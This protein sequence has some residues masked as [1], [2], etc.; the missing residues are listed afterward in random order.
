[1]IFTTSKKLTL[2]LVAIILVLS[3]VGVSATWS[4]G[5]AQIESKQANVGTNL[6]VWAY[7]VEEILPGVGMDEVGQNHQHMIETIV[8]DLRYGLN[9]T[10]KPLIRDLLL[11]DGIGI[12]YVLQHTTKGQLANML[13]KDDSIESVEFAVQYISDTTFAAYTYVK[14]QGEGVPE[15]TIVDCYKTIIVYESGKW[16]ATIAY[17]GKAPVTTITY[18]GKSFPS[19]DVTKWAN[20]TTLVTQ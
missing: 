7:G 1:M 6:P 11:E 18:N 15:G 2:L 3:V 12:V 13:P 19:I 20:A 4:Y 5:A 8:D 17:P 14:L 16:K 9:A 10:Q